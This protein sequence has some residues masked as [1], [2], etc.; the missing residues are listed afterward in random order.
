[1]NV[2][3]SPAPECPTPWD[4]T[5]ASDVLSNLIQ[6]H[7]RTAQP[8]DAGTTS[9]SKLEKVKQPTID[10]GGTN[11]DWQY[12]NQRWSEYKSAT[13]LSGPDVI[14]QL[15][16]C[17]EESLRKDLTRTYGTLI[18]STEQVV[19]NFIKLCAVRAENILVARVQFGQIRKDRY[20]PVRAFAARLRG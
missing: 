15:L 17:C 8:A 6:L 3:E 2:I 4:A 18:S 14:Y 9:T 7:A 16:E 5:L 1:M 10:S 20:E 13:R 19:L 11:E 12:F